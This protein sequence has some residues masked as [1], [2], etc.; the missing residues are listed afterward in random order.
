MFCVLSKMCLWVARWCLGSPDRSPNL[1]KS[2]G[3]DPPPSTLGGIAE[4]LAIWVEKYSEDNLEFPALAV[5]DPLPVDS[6]R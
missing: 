5:E 2:R 4:F 3:S 1:S 6:V